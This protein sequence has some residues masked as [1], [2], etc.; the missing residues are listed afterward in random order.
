MKIGIDISQIVHE[1]TGVSTYT[2]EL[3]K[4]LLAIDQRNEYHLFG[5]SLRKL[6]LLDQFAHDLPNVKAHFYPLPPTVAEPVFNRFPRLPIETFTG[7][8]DLFHTSDWLEPPAKCPKATV[9]HDLSMF[10]F[11]ETVHPKILSVH[12]R[13]LELV[14]KESAAVIAVSQATKNDLVEILKFDPTKIT[15]IYEAASP[16]F[17]KTK[18]ISKEPLL[19]LGVTGKYILAL[20]TREPRKNLSRTIAAFQKLKLKDTKLVIVGKFGWGQDVSPTSDIVLA[21][22]VAQDQIASFYHYAECFLYPSLYE[23]FGLPIL[24]AMATGTPVVTSNIGSLPEVAGKAA[25]LVDPRD[26]EAIVRGI[27][28]ALSQKD[29]L[30][31]RGYTQE[32][33]FSWEKTARE[34]LGL[35]QRI[36]EKK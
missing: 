18:L 26:A 28:D 29:N 11:P 35:Y 27:K 13:K 19:R 21:G 2:R 31:A 14:K 3:V 8:L 4:A 20:G 9:V 6:S 24:E 34:T 30:V 33:K 17:R 23:G 36:S 10:R 1:G 16:D 25:V 15:V 22:Y 7:P 32:K 12:R 5:A